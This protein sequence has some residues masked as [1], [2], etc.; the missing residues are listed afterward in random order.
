MNPQLVNQKLKEFCQRE[1]PSSRGGHEYHREQCRADGLCK[2]LIAYKAELTSDHS[3]CPIC[4]VDWLKHERPWE[5]CDRLRKAAK[6]LKSANCAW[7]VVDA[8][9]LKAEL[10]NIIEGP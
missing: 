1:C 7:G 2:K 6:V 3:T 5:M 8:A 9:E 10:L 4:R